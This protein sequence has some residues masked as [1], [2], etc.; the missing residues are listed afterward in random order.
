M[1]RDITKQETVQI[2]LLIQC[3]H[4]TF[5]SASASETSPETP[6]ISMPLQPTM[7]LDPIT[8]TIVPEDLK[9]I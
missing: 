1:Y 8:V 4:V 6:I 7:T 9:D 3:L 2:P 5:K